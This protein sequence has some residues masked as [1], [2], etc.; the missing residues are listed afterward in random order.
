M[1]VLSIVEAEYRGA[2]NAATWAV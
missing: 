2:M 1:I